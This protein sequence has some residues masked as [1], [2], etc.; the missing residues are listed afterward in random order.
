MISLCVSCRATLEDG[1]ILTV[2]VFL[3]IRLPASGS[4]SI[5]SPPLGLGGLVTVLSPGTGGLSTGGSSCPVM[6][7]YEKVAVMEW[8]LSQFSDMF[9]GVLVC[10]STATAK[11]P[12]LRPC[13]VGHGPAVGDP[14][15][16]QCVADDNT[17]MPESPG[18]SWLLSLHVAKTRGVVQHAVRPGSVSLHGARLVSSG[19]CDPRPSLLGGKASHSH[20]PFLVSVLLLVAY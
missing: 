18:W 6:S 19:V 17:R 10:R 15:C 13:T 2:R 11:R 12:H 14:N 5:G 1:A 3:R 20:R 4:N 7:S 16:D 9:R 8:R